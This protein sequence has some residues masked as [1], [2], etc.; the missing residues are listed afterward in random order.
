MTAKEAIVSLRIATVEGKSHT[1]ADEWIQSQATA[2]STCEE[3]QM[4]GAKVRPNVRGGDGAQLNRTQN[5]G[6]P[7]GKDQ[8]TC[9]SLTCAP[10]QM[11]VNPD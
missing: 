5:A 7:S 3:S 1:Q 11:A 10:C 9:V 6:F 4:R 8:R 2:V